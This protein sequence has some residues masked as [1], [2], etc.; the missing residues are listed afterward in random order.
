MWIYNKVSIGC[1]ISYNITNMS[2]VARLAL[3]LAAVEALM[4]LPG[5]RT[6]GFVEYL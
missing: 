6:S 1:I 4:V 3:A 2:H 5:K